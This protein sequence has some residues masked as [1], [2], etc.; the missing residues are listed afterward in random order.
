MC[1]V[2]DFPKRPCYLVTMAVSTSK[3]K[4]WQCRLTNTRD[5]IAFLKDKAFLS[6]LTIT[7]PGHKRVIQAHRFLLAAH[8]PVFEAMLCG[9]MAEE[10]ILTLVD[11]QPEA[12]D[13][14]LDFIYL[15]KVNLPDVE[16]AIQVYTIAHKYQIDALCEICSMVL[17]TSSEEVLE[18]KNFGLLRPSS[19]KKI[20]GHPKL[21]VSDEGKVFSAIISWGL[22][23]LTAEKCE[24]LRSELENKIS[25]CTADKTKDDG[26]SSAK[27]LS[28]NGKNEIEGEAASQVK[29]NTEKPF[30]SSLRQVVVDFLP[31]V[32]F[33]LMTSD[34]FVRYI[35]PSGVLSN[36]EC[37]AILQNIEG[38]HSIDLPDFV[39]FRAAK[40]RER[41]TKSCL[42]YDR[43]FNDGVNLNFV[44]YSTCCTEVLKD[45]KT[46]RPIFLIRISSPCIS[47]LQEGDVTV[48]TSSNEKIA[49]GTWRG[50]NC[51]FRRPVPLD[52]DQTY[53]VTLSIKESLITTASAVSSVNTEH[54]GV[55]F[56]G[57]T[58]CGA[59]VE[60]EYFVNN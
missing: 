36:G 15:E 12:F 8:S 44:Y 26:D 32:R 53:T 30:V 56:V 57:K 19:L 9:P 43:S 11:D 51:Q 16:M 55:N 35:L 47:S 20:L 29:C 10:G 60:I 38:A 5:R 52:S 41:I 6:D 46:S 17:A 31:F 33:L 59:K 14:L 39:S 37:V 23:Q 13:F 27:K 24:T 50:V 49:K 48:Q 2:A 45:F 42:V 25:Y 54:E 34:Q 40:P 3:S 22:A 7:F 18:S 21:H 28:D 1:L 4:Q 58:R